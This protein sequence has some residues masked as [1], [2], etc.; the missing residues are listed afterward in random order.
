MQLFIPTS[1]DVST[2]LVKHPPF[3]G[4]EKEKL[5]YIIHCIINIPNYNKNITIVDGFVPLSSAALQDI[6]PAYKQ[7]LDYGIKTGLL[8][9]DDLYLAGLKCKGYKILLP[10]WYCKKGSL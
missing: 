4:F 1:L 3:K 8:A 5:L 2:H 6:I 7:Y 9:S 10:C